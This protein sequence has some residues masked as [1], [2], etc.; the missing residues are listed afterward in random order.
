ITRMRGDEPQG[1]MC[2]A[3]SAV[4]FQPYRRDSRQRTALGGIDRIAA[5]PDAKRPVA[6]N[7]AAG[8]RPPLRG[9]QCPTFRQAV[10]LIQHNRSSPIPEMLILKSLTRSRCPAAAGSL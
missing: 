4:G 1:G 5:V 8:R 10:G 6:A 9:G 2:K 7:V 3:G